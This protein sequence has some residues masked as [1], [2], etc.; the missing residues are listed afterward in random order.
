MDDTRASHRT[1]RRPEAGGELEEHPYDYACYECEWFQ[2]MI[3]RARGAYDDRN[4]ADLEAL[5]ARH[6]HL[7]HNPD[8]VH[9]GTDQR[10]ARRHL[11]SV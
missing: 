7:K 5:Q 6:L 3:N 2:T 9:T 8:P 11:R 4:A 10:S 1:D